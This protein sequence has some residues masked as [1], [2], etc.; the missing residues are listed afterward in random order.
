MSTQLT[1]TIVTQEKELLKEQVDQITAPTT[2]GEV[3]ILPN[4]VPLFTRLQTGIVTLKTAGKPTQIV[5]SNGFMDVAPNN[6]VTIL[7]DSATHERDITLAQAEEA[8]RKA[9][10]A[11]SEKK[12]QRDFLIAEASL[13][14]AILELNIA[15]KRKNSTSLS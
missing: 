8:K 12:E 6:A 10:L 11:M 13:R 2:S 4:H 1:L 7:T 9:E 15:R 3:T 5:V 14:K